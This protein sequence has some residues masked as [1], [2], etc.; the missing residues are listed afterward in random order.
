MD[1]QRDNRE[2]VVMDGC[3]SAGMGTGVSYSLVLS[4]MQ[5]C[6]RRSSAYPK[7]HSPAVLLLSVQTW[8]EG[9]AGHHPSTPKPNHI[10]LSNRAITHRP[11]E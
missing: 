8:G 10:A 2:N 11:T 7:Q 5:H 9:K 6:P 1:G 3:A 4:S